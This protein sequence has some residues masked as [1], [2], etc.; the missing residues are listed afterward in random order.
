[1]FLFEKNL[2]LTMGFGYFMYSHSLVPVIDLWFRA[3]TII[4][5]K[6]SI[7]LIYTSKILI[8]ITRSK[9]DSIKLLKPNQDW[10]SR[11]TR[12]LPKIRH[13]LLCKTDISLQKQGQSCKKNT[14]L[15]YQKFNYLGWAPK[16]HK[17]PNRVSQQVNQ[18]KIF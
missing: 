6:I 2:R 8:G 4:T 9:H 11:F 14:L 3:V 12:N 7:N 5:T 1:M 17:L 10:L 15:I 16:L 13:S 18:S